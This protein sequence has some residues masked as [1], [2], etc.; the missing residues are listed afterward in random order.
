M[1]RRGRRRIK[2][3]PPRD[4][5]DATR[6]VLRPAAN[7]PT[8]SDQTTAQPDRRLSLPAA[9][10]SVR[11]TLLAIPALAGVTAGALEIQWAAGKVVDVDG[12]PA[13]LD[14]PVTRP[15]PVYLYRDLPDELPIP[16]EVEILYRD[17]DLVVVDKPHFLATMPRGQ[18]VA[19][20]AL[21][22]LR[23]RLGNDDLAPAHRLDRLTAGVLLFTAR[24]EMRAAYQGLFAHRLARKEYRAVAPLPP[25][26]SPLAERTARVA[27]RIVKTSGDLRAQVV[28]GPVNAISE[29]TV[30]R[31]REDGLAEYRLTPHTGR[32][33]QLRLHMA[34]LGVPILHDPLYPEVDPDLAAAPE[35]GDFSQPLRLVARSLEFTD[36]VTGRERRF[37]S[38]HG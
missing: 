7:P 6:V 33:H 36:P 27:D 9:P 11:E 19:Q 2:P 23:R 31:A 32:T 24:P 8:A 12:R 17:D 18:H 5:V 16:F 10:V 25:P 29:I 21:V 26:G 37:V 28:D 3:L 14:A 15:V 20:T 1:S 22:R 4:G 34:G 35:R 30:E 38:R 13:D